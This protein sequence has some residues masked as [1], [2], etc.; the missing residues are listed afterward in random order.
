MYAI[1]E[2]GGKQYKLSVGDV[3]KVEKLAGEPG[4]KVSLDQVLA[5]SDDTGN[6]TWGTPCLENAKVT[7]EILAQDRAKKIVVLKYKRRKNYKRKQGHRQA[8]TKLKIE[9]ID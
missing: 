1:V 5:V 9:A 8:Y 7:A 2:T 6:L 3:V 4:D